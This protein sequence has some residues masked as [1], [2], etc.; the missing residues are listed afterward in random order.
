MQS[1]DAVEYARQLVE[2][3]G[4]MAVVDAARKASRCEQNGD[5]EAAATWRRIQSAISPG[6][7]TLPLKSSNCVVGGARAMPS[8]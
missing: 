6:L 1:I 4:D 3:R 5:T 7:A 2:I 8:S